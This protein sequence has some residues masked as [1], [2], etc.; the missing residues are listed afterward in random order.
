[1]ILGLFFM[2]IYEMSSDDIR[3]VPHAFFIHTTG[4]VMIQGVF[5]VFIYK[6]SSDDIKSSHLW[7]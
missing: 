7:Y 3:S 6:R 2:L 5:L 1:M 4:V